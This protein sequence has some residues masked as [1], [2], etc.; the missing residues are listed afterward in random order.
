MISY[1]KDHEVIDIQRISEFIDEYEKELLACNQKKI[2]LLHKKI[3]I[4]LI[5]F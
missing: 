5:N 1:L 3:F 4:T 2:T